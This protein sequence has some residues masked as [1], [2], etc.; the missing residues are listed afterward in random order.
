MK[1]KFYTICALVLLSF[2]LVYTQDKLSEYPSHKTESFLYLPSGKYL[3]P[4][5]LGYNQAVG[6][7]LW[8]RAVSYFGNHSMTDQ[9][10][11]WLYH[12][13]NLIIDLDPL[14]DFPYY[15]GGIVLSLEASQPKKAN[16]ILERG[17]K[18]YP[19]KWNYHFYIGFNNYYHLGDP[20]KAIPYMERAASLPDAPAFTQT[21]VGTLHMELGERDAA[22]KFFR[23]LYENTT[24][25][26]IKQKVG[27]R[28]QKILSKEDAHDHS[29]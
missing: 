9:E 25:E 11:P 12:I 28:I 1:K 19:N 4:L 8:I 7:L 24:D 16:E 6:D 17:I 10:Y 22:L 27:Y 5:V 26:M 15:F 13:L 23:E 29:N 21:I 2:S 20:L 18:T 14:F 3:K